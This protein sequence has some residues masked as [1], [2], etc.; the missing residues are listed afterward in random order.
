V[1][2]NYSRFWSD[3]ESI[4]GPNNRLDQQPKQTANV[5]LEYRVRSVQLTLGG[6]LNWTPAYEVQQS[7]TQI[8]YQGLK[9]VVDCYALWKFSPAVQL[10]VAASNMLRRDYETANAVIAGPTDQ[11]AD[12]VTR[13]F[14]AWTT[15]LEVKF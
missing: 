6:N 10:R 13:T 12:A 15:R 11:T 14:L 8:Y 2:A 9:E 7:D 3:V 5:G 4:I 1:R